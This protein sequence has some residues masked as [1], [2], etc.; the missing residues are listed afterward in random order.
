MNIL[1]ALPPP[2]AETSHEVKPTLIMSIWCVSGIYS[3][4]MRPVPHADEDLQT[5][6][7]TA[8]ILFRCTGRYLRTERVFIEDVIILL[9]CLVLAARMV[10]VKF[11]LQYGTNNVEI[12]SLTGEQDVL[13]REIGSQLVLGCRILY[14][15][16]SV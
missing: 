12:A 1:L 8:I 7:A 2:D 16:L 3:T 4:L 5:C 10:L 11:V 9:S 6:Y 15:T 13:N 14:P